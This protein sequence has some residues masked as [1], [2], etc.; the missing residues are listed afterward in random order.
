MM[1]ASDERRHILQMIEDGKITAAEGL[2]L[3]NALSG[4]KESGDETAGRAENAGAAPPPPGSG[5]SAPPQAEPSPRVPN[6]EKWKSWWM[7]PMWIGLSITL[8]GGLLMYW[9][10]RAGGFNFWFVCAGLPFVFGVL[11]MALASATR[12]ARWIHVRVKTGQE[13][14]PRR[15]SVS[16]PLPVRLTAWILRLISPYV[17]KLKNTGVDELI[18]A[19]DEATS[20]DNPLFV[21]VAE[22]EGGE[23]VQVYIG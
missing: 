4:Q 22:G 18:L 23:R 16:F 12:T 5:E 2:R 1:S 9:A 21:D 13:E 3:L 20:P 14:W 15:I 19:L 8:L 17:P 11:V 7:I 6:M 10:Y